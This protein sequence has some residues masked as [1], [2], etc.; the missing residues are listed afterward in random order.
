[1]EGTASAIETQKYVPDTSGSWSKLQSNL[2]NFA[3]KYP[4]G[5]VG[6]ILTVIFVVIAAVGPFLAPQDPLSTSGDVLASP[7][8]AHWFGTDNLGRDVFARVIH[9][10]RISIFVGTVSVVISTL[11]GTSLGVIAGYFGGKVDLVVMRVVDVLMAFP[12]LILALAIMA[13]LGPS[14]RNVIFAVSITQVPGIAR[15]VRSQVLIIRNL[16]FIESTQSVGAPDLRILT[17]HVLPNALPLII[18]YATTNLGYAILTEGT[19]SFLGAGVPPPTPSWGEMISGQARLYLTSAPWM[20][21]FPIGALTLAILG[22]MLLGDSL[23][24]ALDPRLRGT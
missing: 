8:A 15:V 17:H 5:A 22:A 3:R 7:S 21:I 10:A 24:D 9:G 6:G 2:V 14:P 20:A 16:Q 23:R 12:S 19:L 13:M 1:M 11:V 18:V 4:L